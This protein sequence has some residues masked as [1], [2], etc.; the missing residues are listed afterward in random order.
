[1]EQHWHVSVFHGPDARYNPGLV[2]IPVADGWEILDET[3]QLGPPNVS[4]GLFP[5]EL[6]ACQEAL[7]LLRARFGEETFPCW[8]AGAPNRVLA[9]LGYSRGQLRWRWWPPGFMRFGETPVG[10]DGKPAASR[11]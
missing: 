10:V 2:L 6:V 11:T 7:R 3:G 8:G 4:L 1:M 5:S 9:E